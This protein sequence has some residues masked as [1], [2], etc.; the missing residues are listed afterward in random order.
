MFFGGGG[1]CGGEGWVMDFGASG[2]GCVAV[3]RFGYVVMYGCICMEVLC[4][5]KVLVSKKHKW[6]KNK[7]SKLPS[8]P[9]GP[10]SHLSQPTTYSFARTYEKA[11]T[12][13]ISWI[14]FPG[15]NPLGQVREQLR[16]VWHRYRL[17]EL[18][19]IAFLSSLCSSLE[20]AN[21]R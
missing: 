13:L 5:S 7:V 20:S 16:I 10:A 12:F 3:T 17:I 8:T 19:N 15:F 2:R 11:I 6:I 14:A 4:T 1:I 21:H 9:P 18:S